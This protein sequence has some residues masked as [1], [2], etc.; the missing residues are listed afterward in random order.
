MTP[1]ETVASGGSQP[2]RQRARRE[3]V[4]EMI[5]VGV[6]APSEILRPV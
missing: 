3:G 4:E 5:G 1:M 6:P 2:F